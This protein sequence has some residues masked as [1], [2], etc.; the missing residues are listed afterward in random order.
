MVGYLA[1]Y[2]VFAKAVYLAWLK[3]ATD[4]YLAAYLALSMDGCLAA[5]SDA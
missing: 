4:E 2:L 1:A 5:Y 3:A